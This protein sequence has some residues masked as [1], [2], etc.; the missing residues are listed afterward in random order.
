MKKTF[1]YLNLV[2]L[3][4]FYGCSDPTVPV[5]NLNIREIYKYNNF[6]NNFRS[7]NFSIFKNR[8]CCIG[9]E[10][11]SILKYIQLFDIL[12]LDNVKPLSRYKLIDTTT[13]ISNIFN[14]DI[15]I[16]NDNIYSV[17]ND[18]LFWFKIN[19]D[20]IIFENEYK[21]N[22]SLGY[23]LKFAKTDDT[24]KIY[25]L[26]KSNSI[27]Y[28]LTNIAI[29][30][31][32]QNDMI[33]DQYN[34]N[35]DSSG[36]N[37]KRLIKN[38]NYLYIL[39][40]DESTS[41]YPGRNFFIVL[42][43]ENNQWIK[44]NETKIN[45]NTDD[46]IVYGNF[47]ISVYRDYYDH[48]HFNG[49][50]DFDYWGF[51]GI[52]DISNNNFIIKKADIALYYQIYETQLS[53]DNNILC[54]TNT[55][56]HPGFHLYDINDVFNPKIIGYYKYGTFYQRIYYPYIICVDFDLSIFKINI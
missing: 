1:F 18:R 10:Y 54:L 49:Y 52:Y 44:I 42:K 7:F 50:A 53:V 56:H 35:V 24:N 14:D 25:L 6:D 22:I 32:N 9:H 16:I 28:L 34:F 43:S 12:D 11:P 46:F 39:L 4:I 51:I 33:I 27:N 21:G 2:L 48:S 40:G 15:L 45:Y 41:N 13:K 47:L 5:E 17:F 26:G 31:P 23:N 38:N 30:F 20:S 8:L 19:K 3:S 37:I 29:P 36:L 55:N